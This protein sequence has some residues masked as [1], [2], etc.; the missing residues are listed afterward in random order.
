MGAIQALDGPS[1]LKTSAD[2]SRWC[3]TIVLGCVLIFPT[4]IARGTA[5]AENRPAMSEQSNETP[6]P[7]APA[8]D[9]QQQ[10]EKPTATQSTE[11]KVKQLPEEAK[12]ETKKIGEETL[13]KARE[14]EINWLTG[15]YAGR[16]RPLAPLTN[17][18]RQR[19]YLE[20]TFTTP[21][22]Y[23][24]RM[25]VA[26]F[27]Q[28]RESPQQWGDGWGAYGERF[29]SREGQFIT[30]NT[31]TFLGNR[32]LKYEPMY[33]QCE[34]SGFWPRARHAILRNF[35]TYDFTEQRLRPQF[36][37]YGGAFAGG[38]ISATW[39]PS[40]HGLVTNGVFA[41]VG[42]AGYGSLLNIFIEFAVDINRRL[43]GRH[44]GIEPTAA[45]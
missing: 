14:W 36:A 33:D 8:S 28:W 34:C 38:V 15:P 21:N 5:W 23:L 16:Q 4:L 44:S 31:L 13:V 35:L 17:R 1:H 27:D 24:K 19:V 18:Q 6:Q 37:L 42:Q 41:M 29:A 20:Q 11:E 2:W 43:A 40:S 30:A 12:E 39:R 9:S 7:Q 32:A 26:G 25:I 45:K 22:P 10:N 3:R